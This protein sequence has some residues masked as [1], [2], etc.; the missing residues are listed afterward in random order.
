MT[1]IAFVVGSLSQQSINRNVANEIL[2]NAPQG[3][4]IEEIRIDDLPLYTQDLDSQS[5]EAYERVRQQIQAADAVLIVSPEHNR[6]VPAALKNLID[7]ATRPFGQNVWSN[8]KVAIVT[9]SPGAYGGINAGVDLRKIMHAVGANV[10][11]QPEVYL[12]RA[13]SE[14]DERTAGFLAKFANA[15]FQWAE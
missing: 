1:K 4:E 3:V 8:K 10:L 6:S 12:S 14:I 15:F 2:K 11:N 7:I 5:I 13:G 9:A